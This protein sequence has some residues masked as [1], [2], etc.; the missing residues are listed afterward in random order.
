MIPC[1][2]VLDQLI[3][4]SKFSIQYFQ[5]IISFDIISK[6]YA[7][8]IFF[9]NLIIHFTSQHHVPLLFPVLLTLIFSPFPA[10]Y[11]EEKGHLLIRSLQVLLAHPIP[12]TTYQVTEDQA[13]PFPLKPDKVAQLGKQGEEDG[14]RFRVSPHFRCLQA[15]LKTKGHCC[16]VQPRSR[17]YSLFGW[18]FSLLASPLLP[19]NI[20]QGTL[21][22]V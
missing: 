20:P 6:N 21:R 18:C 4:D 2:T 7:P 5:F 11:L 14:N 9:K 1:S 15:H 12:T 19:N 8:R 22:S 16:Y 13:Y 3:A 17:L 10:P